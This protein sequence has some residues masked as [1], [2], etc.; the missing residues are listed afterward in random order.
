MTRQITKNFSLDELTYSKTAEDNHVIN[1]AP[2]RAQFNLTELC[3]HILEPLRE[4]IGQPIKI[5]SGYR[6]PVL[7]G[8]VGGKPDSQHVEGKAV[9]I[10]VEGMSADELFNIIKDNFKYDQVI[11]EKLKN[12]EWVHVSWN[13]VT[14]NRQQAL[15]IKGK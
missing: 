12:R 11:L 15:V 9:D 2:I 4:R 14:S 13:D 5:T 7:N 6:N 10:Q 1:K 3:N 8:L